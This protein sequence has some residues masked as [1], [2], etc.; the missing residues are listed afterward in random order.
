MY[1]SYT[2]SQTRAHVLLINLLDLSNSWMSP[3]QLS[4]GTSADDSDLGCRVL[5][6]LVARAA[7]SMDEGGN[8]LAEHEL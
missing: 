7:G 3:F 6:R 5:L 4:E 8:I 1:V 2:H